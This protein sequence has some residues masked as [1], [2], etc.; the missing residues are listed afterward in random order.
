MP[1]DCP[2]VFNTRQAEAL[3]S[4]YVIDFAENAG[5]RNRTDMPVKARDFESYTMVPWQHMW[6]GYRVKLSALDTV[7]TRWQCVLSVANDCQVIARLLP[8]TVRRRRRDGGRGY[9]CSA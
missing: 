6:C 2:T 4:V 8:A 1:D 5:G 3:N 7:Q 9:G